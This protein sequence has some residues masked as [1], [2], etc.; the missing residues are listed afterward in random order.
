M[1]ARSGSRKRATHL[2]ALPFLLDRLE[3]CDGL[4]LFLGGQDPH[5][6]ER[7]GVRDR[8]ADISGVH[9]LI[10]SQRLIEG[11]H[12]VERVSPVHDARERW[13]HPQGIGRASEPATPQLLFR[14]LIVRRS[15]LPA[16]LV[17]LCIAYW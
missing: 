8:P 4:G 10:V 16:R 5:A 6:G 2:S 9:A 3:T 1:S 11:V 15:R 17:P 7:L 14:R 13:G 12:A